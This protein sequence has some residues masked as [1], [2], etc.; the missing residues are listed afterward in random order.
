MVKIRRRHE[1]IEALKELEA[2]SDVKFFITGG[3]VRDALRNKPAK[4]IDVVAINTNFEELVELLHIRGETKMV[5]FASTRKFGVVLFRVKGCRHI[6]IALPRIEHSTGSGHKEFKV[7][8]GPEITLE[9]DSARRDFK[10]NSMY[11][12]IGYKSRK[13]VIDHQGGAR[14]IKSR[15]IS[16]VGN[17]KERI[18]EDPLRALRLV[19]LQAKTGYR[20]D[21][22]AISAVRD[23]TALVWEV[24]ADR[25]KDELKVLLLSRRP[26][27]SI[28]LLAKLGLL[29]IVIPELDSCRGVKQ[30]K[31]YHKYDVFTHCLKACDF[32]PPVLA[33]RYA[34]LLH[35]IGKP[36]VKKWDKNKKRFTFHNHHKVSTYK[37][38]GALERLKLSNE[39][40]E[41]ICFLIDM[42][43]YDYRAK[44]KSKT[45]RKFVKK[46]GITKSDL[47][48]LDQIPLFQLRIA[49]RLG[50][51]FKNIPITDRQRAFEG[52]IRKVFDQAEIFGMEDLAVNGDDVIKH[53][54]V[55]PGPMVGIILD[56]LLDTA[57]E[58][59]LLN[60]KKELLDL[61]SKL[62]E[63]IEG[64]GIRLKGNWEETEGYGPARWKKEVWRGLKQL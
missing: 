43:M 39:L 29:K 44:W 58:K 62:I 46:I 9:Q 45:V 19:S 7:T 3:Y 10:I 36:K 12:P 23:N 54:R 59:P 32:V 53:L 25:I 20:I 52:R 60:N 18:K 28:R 47:D 26:S 56:K 50:S 8:A 41:E 30:E 57:L 63:E 2:E 37:A 35:D 13:E 6:E 34:A 11:L 31:T 64:L 38:R 33:L 24:P 14:D 55:L 51:G 5:D 22:A 61:S 4:D 16:F 48:E 42:H 1:A 40:I 49:D 27:R 17:A 21:P 15:R